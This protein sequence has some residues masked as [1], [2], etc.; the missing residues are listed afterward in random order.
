MGS[1]S[2]LVQWVEK[3]F[4]QPQ[5]KTVPLSHVC[6]CDTLD[7]TLMTELT[8]SKMNMGLPTTK[9]HK[10]ADTS[11]I[12]TFTHRIIHTHTYTLGQ[13]LQRLQTIQNAAARLITG[14]RRSQHMTPILHQLHWLPIE[15]RILF[16]TAVLV[17]IAQF[18]QYSSHGTNTATKYYKM[19]RYRREY[20]AMRL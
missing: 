1:L 11:S 14:A 18:T 6:E 5:P 10:P 19:P 3:W 9:P 12:P 2:K 7:S 8:V 20:H 13:L 16:K 4:T 17:Y 15:Q